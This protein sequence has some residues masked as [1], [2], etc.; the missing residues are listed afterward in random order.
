MPRY[1]QVVRKMSSVCLRWAFNIS[2]HHVICGIYYIFYLIAARLCYLPSACT[3]CAK[4]T[5]IPVHAQGLEGAPAGSSHFP[6]ALYL[7]IP[8]S[9]AVLNSDLCLL[10]SVELGGS[11]WTV[12]VPMQRARMIVGL[13]LGG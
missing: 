13:S 7:K 6:S 12:L 3:Q 11:T 10:S 1:S 4:C 8:A 2:Q 5:H 9:S